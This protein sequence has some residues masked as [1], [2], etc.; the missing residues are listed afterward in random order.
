MSKISYTSYIDCCNQSINIYSVKQINPISNYIFWLIFQLE[1]IILA[2][3]NLD[4]L[5]SV[6]S[7][8]L[9]GL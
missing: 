6:I 2:M 1:F 9:M 8:T 5:I 3:I 4:C 7:T